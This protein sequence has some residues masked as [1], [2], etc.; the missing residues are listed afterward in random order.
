MAK[1]QLNRYVV[2]IKYNLV[3]IQK[4]KKRITD[5]RRFNVAAASQ[6]QYASPSYG[7]SLRPYI[8]EMRLRTKKL[9][10]NKQRRRAQT[11]IIIIRS[12]SD[13]DTCDS[14]KIIQNEHGH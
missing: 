9:N 1:A 14:I 12:Q 5:E 2:R 10:R 4:K 6:Y 3:D 8:D 11:I 7:S 13:V